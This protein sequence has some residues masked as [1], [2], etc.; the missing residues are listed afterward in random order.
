MTHMD[1]VITNA[2]HKFAF[3]LAKLLL[4]KTSQGHVCFKLKLLGVLT[5]LMDILTRQFQLNKK[6]M[7]MELNHPINAF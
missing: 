6:S 3:D 5:I 2:I 4:K 1:L 7:L